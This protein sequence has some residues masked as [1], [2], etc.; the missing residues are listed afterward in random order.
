VIGLWC[1]TNDGTIV[2]DFRDVQ[3]LLKELRRLGVRKNVLVYLMGWDGAYG[4]RH[5]YFAPDP[6]LGGV[7]QLRSLAAVARATGHRVMLHSS[8]YILDKTT[9]L[10]R[11]FQS[12]AIRDAYFRE[13]HW[14]YSE[15]Q[16]YQFPVPLGLMNPAHSGFQADRLA[17]LRKVLSYGVDGL[18]FDS[19]DGQPN[20]P[21]HGDTYPG[22]K[23]IFGEL[24]RRYPE[25]VLICETPTERICPYMAGFTP[26]AHLDVLQVG[27]F[28]AAG[29][30]VYDFAPFRAM[31]SPTHY[32]FAHD[33]G[34]PLAVPRPGNTGNDVPENFDRMIDLQR[35]RDDFP[36]VQLNYRQYGIDKRAKEILLQK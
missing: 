17:R 3:R 16:C 21:V 23:R 33:G 25:S 36:A 9:P 18:M 5:G 31:I 10:F 4:V 6:E 29:A 2:H 28:R 27:E 15:E 1:K 35:R 12:A 26:G 32:L 14:P 20:D 13:A 7:S 11:Q 19:I 30:G 24:R 34:F 22:L 8:V